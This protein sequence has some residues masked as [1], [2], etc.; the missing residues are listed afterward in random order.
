MA[1]SRRSVSSPY[2]H[3]HHAARPVMPPDVG[4]AAGTH[5]L[6]VSSWHSP[7]RWGHRSPAVPAASCAR[8]ACTESSLA[9]PRP[10]PRGS[11]ACERWATPRQTVATPPPPRL[12]VSG[13]ADGVIAHLAHDRRALARETPYLVPSDDELLHVRGG[14]VI[15][16]DGTPEAAD[17]LRSP[18]TWR[19]S[20]PPPLG[21]ARR[22]AAGPTRSSE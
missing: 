14:V 18:R 21:G 22:K 9:A 7:P 5:H 10:A 8:H 17:V 19:L 2:D 16:R 11:R 6:V 12:S 1:V 13:S 3:C 4:S 20:P 15:G